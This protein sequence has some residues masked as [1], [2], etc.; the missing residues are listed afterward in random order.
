MYRIHT[1][2]GGF[3]NITKFPYAD[4]PA[5]CNVLFPKLPLLEA[6]E[7]QTLT[8]CVFFRGGVD[9]HRK[10]SIVSCEVCN[11]FDLAAFILQY[12]FVYKLPDLNIQSYEFSKVYVHDKNLNFPLLNFIGRFF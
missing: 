10:K 9:E 7:L 1:N 8:E 2:K 11:L 4:L 3:S 5:S 12:L 6:S